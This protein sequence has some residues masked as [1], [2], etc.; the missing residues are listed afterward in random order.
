VFTVA[1]TVVFGIE[2]DHDN[3]AFALFFFSLA[4]NFCLPPWFFLAENYKIISAQFRNHK[5]SLSVALTIF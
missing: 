4:T 1:P 3:P 2:V 5:L